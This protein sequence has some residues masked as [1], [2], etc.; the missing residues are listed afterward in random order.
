MN[1]NTPETTHPGN[2]A[3]VDTEVL[4]PDQ[5]A[6]RNLMEGGLPFAQLMAENARNER[7]QGYEQISQD[8]RA[9]LQILAGVAIAGLG[10]FGV[11]AY[12]GQWGLFEDLALPSLTFLAG[13][14]GGTGH[15]RSQDQ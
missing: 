5:M 2:D 1:E 12:A 10:V 14:I 3:P 13:W 4:P 11:L 15:G 9:K 8:R 7:A 6:L